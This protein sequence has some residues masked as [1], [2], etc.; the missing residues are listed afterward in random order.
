[1]V[2]I[3]AGLLRQLAGAGG[4]ASLALPESD[5]QQRL[6]GYP[7][8]TV[9]AANSPRATIIAGPAG[10]VDEI[11]LRA[12]SEGIRV[13]RIDVDCA[14]HSPAIDP[15]SG[16]LI[17]AL[18]DISPHAPRVAWWSTTIGDW[19]TGPVV[20]G[21][22]WF[23]NLR[24]PVGFAD[25]VAALVEAGYRHF[26]EVSSH[27]VLTPH[28]QD[29][30]EAH[31]ASVVTTPTLYRDGGTP[32][33]VQ[34]ALAHAWVHGQNPAITPT[35][36]A[37]PVALPTYPFQHEHY[38]LPSTSTSATA[39]QDTTDAVFWQTVRDNDLDTL[40]GPYDDEQVM[41]AALPALSAWWHGQEQSI[42]DSWRYR[43]TWTPLTAP[44]TT[45]LPGTWLVVLPANGADHA[46]AVANALTTHGASVVWCE[47]DAMSDRAE[48]ARTIRQHAE[49]HDDITGVLSLLA[50]DEEAHPQEP[51]LPNG[52]ALTLLLAQGLGDAG[53]DT[54]LWLITTGAEAA[55]EAPTRPLQA[56]VGGF[57]R[58]LA[59]EHADRWGGLIDLP[60]TLDDRAGRNLVAALNGIDDEDQ[61]AIRA[62]GIHARRLTRASRASDRPAAYRT[63]RGTALVTGGT[64][65][66]GA[67][68]ARWLAQSGTEHLVLTSRRGPDSPDAAELRHELEDIGARVTIAAC[69]VTEAV[70]LE[71][72][73]EGLRSDGEVVRTV[74]HTAGVGVLVPL[75][76]TTLAEFAEGAE[77]RLVGARTLDRLFRTDELDAFVLFSSVAG[78]WGSGDHGACAASN[79]YVDALAAHRRARGLAGT[80]IP[81]GIWSP[82]GGG[83]GQDVVSTRLKWRGIRFMEPEPAVEAMALALDDDETLIAIA[84]ID[85]ERFVPVFT[86]ARRRPLLDT[87]PEVAALLAED[88]QDS[89]EQGSH[90]LL[91]RLDKAPDPRQMLVDLVRDAVAGALGYSDASAVEVSRAFRELGFDSLTAVGLRNTL[92]ASTGIRLPVTVVFDHPTV[93]ALADYLHAELRPAS[94]TPVVSGPEVP[95][96]AEIERLKQV[97]STLDGDESA[98]T[99]LAKGLQEVLAQLGVEVAG[100]EDS[101]ATHV[102]N[103][104]DEELFGFVDSEFGT[105]PDGPQV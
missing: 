14:S 1:V 56:A 33:Q 17:P 96:V 105:A 90:G 10:K 34:T 5:V 49:E 9:A 20:D 12:E 24:R 72:L 71:A 32:A 77:A 93:T 61:I 73:V 65:G 35:R 41:R 55:S 59:L 46:D 8:V 27:P 102:Q 91:E 21:G 87:V 103:A 83:M 13:R 74:V 70:A 3:R 92:K 18:A 94:V 68:T 23:A 81:W 42:Q 11:V 29:T 25:G 37:A 85:W 101:V 84:D 15:L 57:G 7:G 45:R 98:R 66:L 31:E 78:L 6:V 63:S 88:G 82:S 4:M 43:I 97:V 79:A 99:A 2:A 86:A 38:W 64:G 60:E 44:S 50:A 76:D 19:I 100:A 104:S 26:I 22:Y 51:A 95:G 16:H 39:S 69:D 75:A 36:Q 53:I 30:A 80:S 62:D 54:P 48:V 47:L 28:I 89:I 58:V 52:L 67:H 40:T